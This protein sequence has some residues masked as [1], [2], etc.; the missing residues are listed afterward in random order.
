[1]TKFLETPLAC[2]LITAVV[3]VVFIFGRL[4]QSRF[5]PSSFVVAGD[6]YSDPSR[7]PQSLTVLKDSAGFDGQFYYR[8]ALN[9][10]TSQPTEFGITLD[11]P[12]LRHQRI[13]YPLLSSVLSLGNHNLL[14]AVMIVVTSWR[15][16]LMDGSEGTTLKA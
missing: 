13:L 9:P 2:L 12:P 14:P 7:V 11:A 1:M 10:F 15:L 3:L 16:C 6:R 4:Y 5:D 8:L